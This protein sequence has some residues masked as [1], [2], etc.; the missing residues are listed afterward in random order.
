MTSRPFSGG[1]ILV[2][3]MSCNISQ[4]GIFGIS[5]DESETKKILPWKALLLMNLRSFLQ[6][7]HQNAFSPR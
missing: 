6:S 5:L 7:F 1:H 2:H 4:H 3:P